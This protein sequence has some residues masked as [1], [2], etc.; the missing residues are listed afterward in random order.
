MTDDKDIAEVRAALKDIKLFWCLDDSEIEIMRLGGDTNRVFRVD[1]A[2]EQYVLRL[3]GKSAGRD[4]EVEAARA[5]S[6]A[7]VAP[8][9][10]YFDAKSALLITRMVDEAVTMSPENFRIAKGSPARAAQAL[11]TLHRSG[12]TFGRTFKRP[13][14][15]PKPKTL[16]PCHCKPVCSNLLDT[17]KRVWLVDWETAA[18]GDP[19]WDLACLSASALFSDAQEAEFLGAYFAEMPEQDVEAYESLKAMQRR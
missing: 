8:D 16:A 2:G 17:G 3:A 14:S 5:A 6:K 9:V 15:A 1:H 4:L 12:V 13:K 19:L 18:M 7:G 10:V 11:Q